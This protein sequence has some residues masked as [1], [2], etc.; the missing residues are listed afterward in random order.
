MGLKMFIK[1]ILF[2]IVRVCGCVLRRHTCGIFV[3][4]I[5]IKLYYSGGVRKKKNVKKILK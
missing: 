5:F 4:N 3:Y 2:I 1:E